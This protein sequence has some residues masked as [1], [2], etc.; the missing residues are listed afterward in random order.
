[1][2]QRLGSVD[3]AKDVCSQDESCYGFQWL[4]MEQ[5]TAIADTT[6]QNV[7]SV[8]LGA[9][10]GLPYLDPGAPFIPAQGFSDIPPAS[11]GLGG[12]TW[13]ELG[14]VKKIGDC[15][16]CHLHW[17]IL[18]CL[19]ESPRAFDDIFNQGARL[20]NVGC[21][22]TGNFLIR[23]LEHNV[24]GKHAKRLFFPQAFR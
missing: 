23:R 20:H 14:V 1:M 22:D 9:T 5:L 24:I 15:H 17:N 21:A 7:P 11:W 8:G 10:S 6:V 4:T 19:F 2:I 18:A 13:D 16:N 12:S 3:E